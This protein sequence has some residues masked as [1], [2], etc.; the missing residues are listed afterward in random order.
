MQK[1]TKQHT[2]ESRSNSFLHQ[3]KKE[4]KNQINKQA[5]LKMET[6]SQF[7]HQ[8]SDF[9]WTMNGLRQTHNNIKFSHDCAL[10]LLLLLLLLPILRD[11]RRACDTSTH[12]YPKIWLIIYS[13]CEFVYPAYFYILTVINAWLYT[14]VESSL[15]SLVSDI[16]VVSF[17]S[18]AAA[19]DS[20]FLIIH[21]VFSL[22]F[23]WN[24][25]WGPE[26]VCVLVA[27]AVVDGD[28]D[29]LYALPDSRRTIIIIRCFVF[30]TENQ[31]FK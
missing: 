6:I 14:L 5:N 10:L 21:F 31:N 20:N 4:T 8:D 29:W 24:R 26:W 23:C 12:E 27:V 17:R 13:Y 1:Q 3:K 16:D 15:V 2:D 22:T 18:L 11:V 25:P 19:M 7:A 28:C 30:L 9:D